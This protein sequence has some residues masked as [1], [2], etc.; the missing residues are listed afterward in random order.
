MPNVVILMSTWNGMTYLPEQMAS[1]A[2]QDF[3]GHLRLL[4]RD[5]GSSDGTVAFLRDYPGLDVT[6]IEGENIGARRSFYE[7]L[8]L[9]REIEGD[10]F[11]LC[12]QD[13]VWKKDKIARAI[14]SLPEGEPALY[15]SSLDLVRADLSPMGHV[16][17]K[18][19]Q[20][21][22]AT[23]F[24]NFVTGCTCV[25]NRRFIDYMTL[26]DN[27][28]NTVMHDWWLATL[29]TTGPK[30]VYDTTSGILYRQHGSNQAGL[31]KGWRNALTKIRRLVRSGVRTSRFDHMAEFLKTSRHLLG[32]PE[33][34]MTED[35]L[36]ART[37]PLRRLHFLMRHP[38]KLERQI[39]IRFLLGPRYF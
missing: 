13:D 15:A 19:D 6:V 27:P 33:A 17:H 25:M 32:A 31:K 2:A 34:Q 30:I 9:A 29:A 16:R 18:S 14:T 12:D 7:L 11:A 3:A 38:Q 8:R 36:R 20:S 28:D 24:M 35:F 26:P 4:V 22:R 10:F 23:L 37:N 21:F 1:L 39:Y 5:D